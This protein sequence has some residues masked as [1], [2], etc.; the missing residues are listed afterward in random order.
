MRGIDI[1]NWQK[2]LNLKSLDIDFC[3]CKATEGLDFVDYTCDNFIKQCI[4]KNICWG[5]YHFA[6]NE[7]PES[8]AE[9]F[10][11]NCKGYIGK[12]IPILDY[13]TENYNNREWCERFIK[14]FHELSGIWCVLYISAYRCKE[15]NSSWIP[16]KCGLWI[17]GY[18]TT[19]TDWTNDK[20]P[21]DCSP[22]KF[23]AI[24][25]FTSSLIIPGFWEKLDGDIAYMDKDAW[26]KYAKSTKTEKTPS[27]PKKET[28]KS[29]DDLVLETLLGEY[30]TGD[31]RKKLLGNNYNKVQNRINELYKIA[32]EVIDGKWGNGW[33]REQALNGAGYPYEIVQ[34]IVN[35]KLSD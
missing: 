7:R 26:M 33:N 32:D 17:A 21:Y 19:Y 5:F 4:N 15:Y 30:G 18:P 34:K 8:E 29:I 16:N 25:Q 12:G 22:W 13:E 20:M 31:D 23:A 28:K 1:S 24:W 6:N 9:F 2:G 3:I 27:T 35:Q 14:R 10:Y 11:N